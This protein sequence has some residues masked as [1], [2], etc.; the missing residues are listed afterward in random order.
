MTRARSGRGKPLENNNLPANPFST[1]TA[2]RRLE[3][4]AEVE[5]MFRHELEPRGLLRRLERYGWPT[6]RYLTKTEVHT[7]AF[8]VAANSFRSKLH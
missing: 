2:A 4:E 7:Y 5:E 6:L 1:G 3:A 8:S